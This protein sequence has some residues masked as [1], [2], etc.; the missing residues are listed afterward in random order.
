VEGVDFRK[1]LIFVGCIVASLYATADP[2]PVDGRGGG[3]NTEPVV[4]SA[5]SAM[6][7]NP[8]TAA[9]GTTGAGSTTTSASQTNPGTSGTEHAPSSAGNA[10]STELHPHGGQNV[11]ERASKI[12][13]VDKLP[14]SGTDPRFSGSL[15]DRSVSSIDNVKAAA[16][17]G[18]AAGNDDPRFRTKSSNPDREADSRKNSGS[19]ASSNASPAPSA[20]ANSSPAAK[21]SPT[22]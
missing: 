4:Q 12:E 3:Y 15:L 8:G 2:I 19:R 22:R 9:T 6:D 7:N 18:R 20:A 11:V 21:A 5:G 10:S 16:S 1:F 13:S 14:S 17:E